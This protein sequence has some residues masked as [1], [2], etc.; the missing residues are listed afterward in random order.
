MWYLIL[1]VI[2]IISSTILFGTGL[3]SAFYL[4][5]A[6]QTNNLSVMSFATRNVV[7][8]DWAFTTP[9]VVIQP[10]TGILL[11]YIVG[12]P[13]S[14]TWLVLTYL[15]FFLTGL[16]WLP[17]V[18]LQIK[19]RDLLQQAIEAKTPIPAKYYDYYRIWF[20][21]GWPAFLAVIIIFFLM[22]LKP[23]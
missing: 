12:Y 10:L 4:W 22:V 1:K 20:M 21:L 17:V 7:I 14:S 9:A 2:H 3:G 11:V 15:L 16:C 19:M 6:H 13:V 8:A 5:R 18:W 23:T